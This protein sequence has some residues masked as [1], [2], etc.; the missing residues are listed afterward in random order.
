MAPD[1]CPHAMCSLLPVGFVLIAFDSFHDLRWCLAPSANTERQLKEYY[2]KILTPRLSPIPFPGFLFPIYVIYVF[3]GVCPD[4]VGWSLFSL[5]VP[6][7]KRYYSIKQGRDDLGGWWKVVGIRVLMALLTY[8]G[9]DERG[10]R[11]MDY[12]DNFSTFVKQSNES[13]ITFL[14]PIG[15]NITVAE[16]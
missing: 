3:V 5:Y 10:C 1:I 13:Y 9:L 14:T 7:C 6:L 4:W 2:M 16:F 8:K 12:K 11:M 15:G